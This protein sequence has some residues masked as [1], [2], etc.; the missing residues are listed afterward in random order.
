MKN[1]L[2]IV[3]VYMGEAAQE[4]AIRMLSATSP[5]TAEA[6][7][8]AALQLLSTIPDKTDLLLALEKI[9]TQ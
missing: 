3:F 2:K 6:R 5:Q 7:I 8:S 4:K 1:I 9:L